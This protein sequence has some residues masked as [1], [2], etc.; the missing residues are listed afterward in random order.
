MQPQETNKGQKGN[1]KQLNQ[2]Q[3]KRPD[4]QK[5][6]KHRTGQKQPGKTC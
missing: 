6:D 4:Q 1:Q 2:N 3:D 5:D